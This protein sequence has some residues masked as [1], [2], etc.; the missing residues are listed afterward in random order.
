MAKMPLV[1]SCPSASGIIPL[2]P[3]DRQAGI[4]RYSSLD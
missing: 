1:M 4:D 2:T 3:R